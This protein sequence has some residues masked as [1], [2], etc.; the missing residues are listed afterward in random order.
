MHRWPHTPGTIISWSTV[1]QGPLGQLEMSFNSHLLTHLP[2]PLFP[3]LSPPSRPPKKRLRPFGMHPLTWIS[4]HWHCICVLGPG[5]GPD[6]WDACCMLHVLG[7]LF[8]TYSLYYICITT[9][10]SKLQ[11][12]KPKVSSSRHHTWD[13]TTS[14]HIVIQ[15]PNPKD[16]TKT[17]TRWQQDGNKIAP[18]LQQDA[19]RCTKMASRYFCPIKYVINESCNPEPRLKF[20]MIL[21]AL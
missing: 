3:S 21:N 1:F 17:T 9:T 13:S 4:L 19:S 16:Q 20:M 7:V 10:N 11:V 14:T 8:V 15:W 5:L 2:S 6:S 12:Q 18:R